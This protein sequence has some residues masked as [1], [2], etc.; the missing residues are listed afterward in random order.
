MKKN[1]IFKERTCIYSI[2]IRDHNWEKK[3]KNL[4]QSK[5]NQ[6]NKNKEKTKHWSVLYGARFLT[7]TEALRGGDIRFHHNFIPNKL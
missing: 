2:D 5:L 7:V 4:T 3:K 1:L 6:A